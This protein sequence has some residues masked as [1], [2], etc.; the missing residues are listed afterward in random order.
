MLVVLYWIPY[1]YWFIGSPVHLFIR[2]LC[3]LAEA[4][5]DPFSKLLTPD[6]KLLYGLQI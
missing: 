5:R 4:E 3:V 6:S 2:V 1:L